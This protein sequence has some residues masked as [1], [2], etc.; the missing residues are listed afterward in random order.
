[1]TLEEQKGHRFSNGNGEF[2]AAPFDPSKNAGS[3]FK[4]LLVFWTLPAPRYCFLLI[5][6]LCVGTVLMGGTLLMGKTSSDSTIT[7][8]KK[9]LEFDPNGLCWEYQEIEYLN[10]IIDFNLL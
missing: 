10:S 8:T 9:A 5:P 7:P 3:L 4:R 6:L 2:V 1:M